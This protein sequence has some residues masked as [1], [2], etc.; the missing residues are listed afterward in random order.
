MRYG[1]L[2]YSTKNLGDDIQSLAARRFLPRVDVLVDRE[3]M[4]RAPGPDPFKIILNGWFTSRPDN[5]PPSPDL[6]A[7]F[8]S[9]HITRESVGPKERRM[10]ASDQLMQGAPLDYLRRHQPIGCRDLATVALLRNHGVEAYFSGC[11]TL[12]LDRPVSQR[13]DVVWCVDAPKA[14]VR[15]VAKTVGVEVR[16]MTHILAPDEMD[17]D[18]DARF[19]RAEQY[20]QR[21]ATAR[22]VVTSR[23]H[24]AMPCLALGTPVVFVMA[25]PDNYRLSGLSELTRAFTPEQILSD[26]ADFDWRDPQPNPKDIGAMRRDLIDRCVAFT[27]RDTQQITGR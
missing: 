2:K 9:T 3:F 23:L 5:W 15:H 24:C 19:A 10:T 6:L 4:N 14:V 16:T 27:G 20:L 1:L 22:L 13:Q 8:I 12:T 17:E 7:L 25:E 26:E 11:L 21:Y 18:T